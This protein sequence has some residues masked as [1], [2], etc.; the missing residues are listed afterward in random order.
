[1]DAEQAR[2]EHLK[3]IES[4]IDR[5]SRLSFAVKASATALVG[6]L[7]AATAALDSPFVTLGLLTVL[8]LWSID[9]LYLWEERLFRGLFREVRLAPAAEPGDDSYFTMDIEELRHPLPGV[10]K[11]MRSWHVSLFYVALILMGTATGIAAAV[12]TL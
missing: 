9:S 5:L 6:A 4:V 12:G 7:I 2:I 10:M 1:M 11:T 3:M 8:V